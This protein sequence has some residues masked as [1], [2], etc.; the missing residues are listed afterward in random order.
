MDG[1]SVRSTIKEPLK[2]IIVDESGRK[3]KI[4]LLNYLVF[5]DILHHKVHDGEVFIVSDIDTDV[6]TASPKYWHIKTPAGIKFHMRINL[7]TDTGGLVEFFEDPTTTGDGTALVAYNADRNAAKTTTV[8][9]YYDPTVSNDGT[10]IQVARIGAGR[11][12]K[13]GGIAR[14]QVEWILKKNEQYLVKITPDANDA[15]VTMNLEGY[16]VT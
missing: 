16:E 3:A 11:D 6:D 7:E 14:A 8:E 12:K 9:F 4:D 13:L 10:R 1:M 15:E 5:I 2:I